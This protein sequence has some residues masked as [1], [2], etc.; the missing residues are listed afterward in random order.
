M[1][2][3][4]GLTLAIA[5]AAILLT[6]IGAIAQSGHSQSSPPVA[7][8]QERRD[9]AALKDDIQKMRGLLN[10]MQSNLA[11]VGSTTTPLNHQ[12]QLEIEMW[13]TLLDHM[14]REVDGPASSSRT[15][16]Q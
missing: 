2:S 13:R 4:K 5:L 11:F 12:F 9:N 14:E 6:S 10:Q 15:H 8:S 3:G 16:P 7:A 1:T